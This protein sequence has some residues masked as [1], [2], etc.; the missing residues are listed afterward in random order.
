MGVDDEEGGASGSS[1]VE[2]TEVSVRKSGERCARRSAQ[3][4]LEGRRGKS[5]SITGC[6]FIHFLFMAK[7]S[8][9]ELRSQL[10]HALDQH[11]VAEAIFEGIRDRCLALSRQISALI[12]YLESS[13]RPQRKSKL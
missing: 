1:I 7:A 5:E 6:L 13:K 8:A 12:E 10:N 11:Y 9:G 3:F 4:C 2:N